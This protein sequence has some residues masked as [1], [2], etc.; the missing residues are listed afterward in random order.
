MIPYYTGAIETGAPQR[1]PA[2]STGGFRSGTLLRSME[3]SGADF[4][5]GIAIRDVSGGNGRGVGTLT[6]TGPDSLTWTAPGATTAGAAVTVAFGDEAVVRGADPGAWVRVCRVGANPLSGARTVT[7]VDRLNNLFADV[8]TADAVAG[9]TT[10]RAI[11]LLHDLPDDATDFEAWVEGDIEIALEEPTAGELLGSGLT[12]SGATT[13]GAGPGLA[14]VDGEGEVGV[15]VRRVIAADTDPSGSTLWAIHYSYTCDGVETT[16]AIR[17]LYRVERTDFACEGIWVG[18]DEI[19][20]TEGAPDETWTT[21]PHTTSLGLT[22]PATVWVVRRTRNL[23]GMWG[24]PTEAQRYDLDA[25]GDSTLLAPSGPTDVTVG[26]TSGNAAT[27]GATYDAAADSAEQ[28]AAIWCIWLATDGTEPD[29]TG[30]PDGY[31]VMQPDAA[32]DDLAWASD[33]DGLD[34]GTPVNALVRTRRLDSTGGTAFSP[35]VIQLTASGAGVLKVDAE[36]ADWPASG[37]A[38]IETRFGRLIEVVHFSGTA[39][40]TGQTTVTVDQRGL[41]GTTAAAT[42][43]NLIVTPVEAVDSE[44]TTVATWEIVAVALGRTRGAALYGTQAAQVQE[45][46]TGPDGV[47]PVV[48]HVGQN[49]HLLL[50]EGW[51]SLYADTTLVWRALL[52]GS[53]GE[54]N[55]LYIPSEFDLIQDDV[56]GAS[57]GSGPVDAPDANTVYLCVR[58]QRRLKID[59]S[60][61]EI[62]FGGL[63]SAATVDRRAEQ[64]GELER[65]GGTMLLGWDCDAEDYRPYLE[66]DSDGL[67][68]V[69]LG[70]NQTL[71]AAAV[72]AL[73]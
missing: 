5:A 56:T 36:I 61:M 12:W 8:A 67:L 51:A 43:A 65:F 6:A 73:W 27:V 34:D 14:T 24:A 23:H 32:I 29:G 4:M 10:T 26:Q 3:W 11:M 72:G 39:V 22:L 44:N 48:L 55:G 45:A 31:V 71:D 2:D 63:A 64:A 20:D 17:G 46:L 30:D 59:L 21:T 1:T 35:D 47:T 49:V 16:G 69:E 58:G 52:N 70:I 7:C 68:S 28:R 9:L 38:K 33:D 54:M 19:P 57:G 18:I 40:A 42:T 62:T 37:Y 25:V 66:V 60:A 50:G 53:H 41:M 15:H 13:E